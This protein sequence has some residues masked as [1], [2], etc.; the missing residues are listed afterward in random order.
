MINIVIILL[1]YHLNV[2]QHYLNCKLNA[3]NVYRDHSS[4]VTPVCFKPESSSAQFDWV[5]MLD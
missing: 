5:R 2:N 4:P 1:E 3:P